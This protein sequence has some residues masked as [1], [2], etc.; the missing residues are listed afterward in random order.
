MVILRTTKVVLYFYKLNA[1]LTL[2]ILET[3]LVDFLK[4]LE[5]YAIAFWAQVMFNY[6]NFTFIFSRLKFGVLEGVF[7]FTI[8]FINKT[9]TFSNWPGLTVGAWLTGIPLYI[10]ATLCVALSYVLAVKHF[11]NITSAII[12]STMSSLATSLFFARLRTGEELSYQGWLAIGLI[13]LASFFA[14]H[15]IKAI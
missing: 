6:F 10:P 8:P 4:I 12:I 7:S 3:T 1:R 13:V 11:G 9:F 14:A 15:P 2:S 5:I